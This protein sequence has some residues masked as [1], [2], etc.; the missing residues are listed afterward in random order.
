MHAAFYND[1][2]TAQRHEVELRVVVD[3]LWLRSNDGQ[4]DEKWDGPGIRLLEEA[5]SGKPLRL[6]HAGNPDAVITVTHPDT[7]HRLLES[8]PQLAGK[9]V[10]GSTTHRLIFWTG[11][12]V[13]AIATFLVGIPMLAVSFAG[14]IPNEWSTKLGD[15]IVESLVDSDTAC[16]GGEGLQ[17]LRDFT[18]RLQAVSA[19]SGAIEL[20]VADVSAVNAIAAPGGNIVVFRGVIEEANSGDQLAGVVA[21]E[22]AHLSE[23]HP[24]EGLAHHLALRFVLA[25]IIGDFNGLT[26]AAA[27]LGGDAMISGYG[28]AQE[29]EADRIAVHLLNDAG[30]DAGGLADFFRHQAQQ[31]DDEPPKA[32]A[33]LSTHPTHRE[34]ID[35]LGKINRG[36]APAFDEAQ[37]RAIQ[38]ICSPDPI[39][40]APVGAD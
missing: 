3:R 4:V 7:R 30:Y 40:V 22:L 13:A 36:G 26:V 28:R 20:Q 18:E 25:L 38:A 11:L 23:N 39:P 27:D 31:G 34:R 19:Y 5:Y 33:W 35:A 2:K 17:A 32:L 16:T 1:G 15:V 9:V 6:Q 12:T 21:H 24:L 10:H 29:T 8:F 14:H 37:W